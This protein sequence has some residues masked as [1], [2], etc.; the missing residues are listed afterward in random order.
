MTR[1]SMRFLTIGLFVLAASLMTVVPTPAQQTPPADAPT[2]A[3]SA[4][5]P[6]APESHV[7]TQT[8]GRSDPSFTAPSLAPGVDYTVPTEAEII[9]ALQRIHAH[10]VRSTPFRIVDSNTGRPITDFTQPLKSAAVDLG[11]GEFGDWTYSMGVVL[12]GMLQASEVTRDSRYKEYTFRYVDFIH[13]HLD[14]FRRQ[15]AQFGPQPR[16]YR[17]LLEMHE[18]DDCGAIGAALIRAYAEK[19]DSRY[20]ATIDLAADFISHKMK[21]MPDG[22]LVRPRPQPVS[23]WADDL[24]MSVPFLA[25]MGELTGDRR[26]F[27]DAARQVIQFSDRL[28]SPTSGLFDHAWFENAGHDPKFYW[29]RADGWMVMAMAELLSV[30]PENHPLRTRVLEIYQRAVQG[31]TAMQTGTGMWRQL[32]D[33]PDSY[34]ETSATAMFTYAIARGVNRGWLSPVYA[35]V[36]QAGWQALSKRIHENGEIEGICVGTTAAYDA[37]YYYNRP[38]DLGAMQGYGPALLAG[39]EMITMLRSFDIERKL[40]TYHY[41]AKPSQTP[42]TKE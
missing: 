28:M 37:V 30:I 18:L 16:G 4:R 35:P 2:N 1:V 17:R 5:T 14:Y 24:Y 41:R 40:N 29:G 39:A 11:T 3:Q 33:K 34:E 27:D 12:T 38:T 10:F 32:L 8:L 21:R 42:V 6:A 19:K 36:A 31:V 26:Y 7:S 9:S 25:R 13:D 20:R 23:L 15:A 22:T